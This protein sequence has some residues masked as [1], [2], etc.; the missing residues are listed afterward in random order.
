MPATIF[1]PSPSPSIVPPRTPLFSDGVVRFTTA[2][3]PYRLTSALIPAPTAALATAPSATDPTPALLNK[4]AT[5]PTPAAVHNIGPEYFSK[6]LTVLPP[7]ELYHGS[8]LY[9]SS[10]SLSITSVAAGE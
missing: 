4:P 7:A 5:K 2:L 3:T 9:C 1:P 10:S 8:S 6:N